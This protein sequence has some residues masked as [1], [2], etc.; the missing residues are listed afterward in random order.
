MSLNV[1]SAFTSLIRHI[2]KSRALDAAARRPGPNRR[3][4][5]NPNVGWLEMENRQSVT[6]E[7]EKV[8]RPRKKNPNL[9]MDRV[10]SKSVGGL[11]GEKKGGCCVVQ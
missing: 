9:A 4:D 5:F 2:I 3:S 8:T 6:V 11:A 1:E 7:E 10:N